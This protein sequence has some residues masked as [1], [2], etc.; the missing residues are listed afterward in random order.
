MKDKLSLKAKEISIIKS[1]FIILILMVLSG[2]LFSV[3]PEE[4][5]VSG[6]FDVSLSAGDPAEDP[7]KDRI[8]ALYGQ[9]GAGGGG[10]SLFTGKAAFSIDVEMLKLQYSGNVRKTIASPNY[11]VQ[12]PWV[13]TGW[14]LT[15]GHISAVQNNTVELNDDIYYLVTEDGVSGELKQIGNTDEFYL[16]DYKYWLI[17]RFK[18][19][20]KITHW[21]V[22]REDGTVYIYG[23]G[24][25]GIGTKKGNHCTLAWDNWI[26]NGD[27]SAGTPDQV[28]YQWDLTEVKNVFNDSLLTIKYWQENE[29]LGGWSPIYTKAS[30]PDVITERSG[31]QIRFIRKDR[32]STEWV[33]QHNYSSEPDAFME[34]YE[35]KRLDSIYVYSPTG[36]LVKKYDFEYLPDV[37]EAGHQD[38]GRG[39]QFLM[40]LTEYDAHNVALPS[41]MFDYVD[42]QRDENNYEIS[43][44]HYYGGSIEKVTY[45]SGGYTFFRYD[46]T[47]TSGEIKT[48]NW[49]ILEYEGLTGFYINSVTPNIFMND[50][51]FLAINC[52]GL[53]DGGLQAFKDESYLNAYYW[54]GHQWEE[55]YDGVYDNMFGEPISALYGHK[56]GEP[57]MSYWFESTCFPN[58]YDVSHY[59]YSPVL[60]GFDDKIA[61]ITPPASGMPGKLIAWNWISEQWNRQDPV[62]T[63]NGVNSGSAGRQEPLL[64]IT[65]TKMAV[66]E[67]PDYNSLVWKDGRLKTYHWDDSL[68]Q[69]DG[70]LKDTISFGYE[71]YNPLLMMNENHL[72]LMFQDT[73]QYWRLYAWKWDGNSWMATN[74]WNMQVFGWDFIGPQMLLTVDKLIISD[75]NYGTS[76]LHVWK[77]TGESWEQR[78]PAFKGPFRYN[79]EG[80][81]RSIIRTDGEK[82]ILLDEKDGGW[83]AT[84]YAWHWDGEQFIKDS[85]YAQTDK[86][87]SV[88]RNCPSI[89]ID[90]ELYPIV[91]LLNNKI[92]VFEP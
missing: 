11:R 38:E 49:N 25:P 33:D 20:N 47:G 66:L 17:E 92:V 13:G 58:C 48:H 90:V 62:D 68:W 84:M 63:I 42:V 43:N 29:T 44:T 19:G 57:L 10:I 54:D 80:G 27:S 46:S 2:M 56:S 31:R 21:Q 53:T 71:S 74:L 45:P 67:D 51:H 85:V 5:T 7:T 72:I 70:I 77:W 9:I 41:Y 6:S 82:L 50:K 26:G 1:I 14:S 78:D 91:S 65:K 87:T 59:T 86:I 3:L 83:Q 64:E 22:T 30:Y 32:D 39:K 40:A 89:P 36:N 23:D 12:A 69:S 8:E 16:E 18:S 35:T 24:V 76:Y 4:G 75:I 79:V 37:A 88:P 15:M 60:K 61:L 34:Q 55:K 52:W 81:W 28:A 73:Y